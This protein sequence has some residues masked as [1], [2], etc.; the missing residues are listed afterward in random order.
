MA[1]KQTLGVNVLHCR[2]VDG[3][4]KELVTFVIVYNLAHVVMLR[5]AE[6]QGVDRA[7]I[8]FIDTLRWLCRAPPDD[9]VP[10]LLTNPYRP[11]RNQPRVIKR[12]KDCYSYMTKPR[13]ALLEGLYTTV[14]TA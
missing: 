14:V 10:N 8:S 11:R 7:R 9:L 12:R 1:L 13:A 6:Q 5:S 2:T 4:M 3:V